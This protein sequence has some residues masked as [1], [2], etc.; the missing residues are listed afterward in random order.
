MKRKMTTIPPEFEGE[1]TVRIVDMPVASPGLVLFDDDDHANVYL[2]ARYNR[3]TNENTADHELI[4]LLNDDIH[5]DDDIR[6]VEARADGLPAPLKSL[7][8]L[9]KASDLLPHTKSHPPLGRPQ[10]PENSPVDCFQRGR[11]GR[12]FVAPAPLGSDEA[13]RSPAPIS[14]HQAAVLLHAVNDLDDWLFRDTTYDL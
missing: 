8:H 7:P 13:P 4:H 6:T 10:C 5:N 9:I 14:P 3:E 11:A 2:N 12:P 1:Y